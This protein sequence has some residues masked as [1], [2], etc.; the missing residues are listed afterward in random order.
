MNMFIWFFN[1]FFYN[2]HVL[3]WK[4]WSNV[5]FY[6]NLYSLNHQMNFKLVDI[7]KCFLE[8]G[9]GE[10]SLDLFH[11]IFSFFSKPGCIIQ[12]S[13][14]VLRGLPKAIKMD[15]Q[16]LPPLIH[17]GLLTTLTYSINIGWV[18]AVCKALLQ[19]LQ[20]QRDETIQPLPTRKI[21]SNRRR[22]CI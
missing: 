22:A 18:S 3:C 20:E 21:P 16:P 11:G 8:F 15:L 13:L 19:V 1:I 10:D 6:L 12:G 9:E 14:Q 17:C 5:C 4:I 2:W 7:N